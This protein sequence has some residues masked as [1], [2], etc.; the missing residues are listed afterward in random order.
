MS[1]EGLI[2]GRLRF[3]GRMAVIAIAISFFIMIVAVA[4]SSG[5]RKEIR[6][7]V[8]EVSGDVILA[9]AS[10]NYFGESDPVACDG[11]ALAEILAVEGVAD[12]TPVVYRA[13]IVKSGD[14]ISG[15]LVKGV[16]VTDTLALQV[17]IPRRLASTMRLS[18]GD[19]M[20]TYF[21]GEKVK[22]RRFKVASVYDS[23]FETGE[24]VTVYASI[25]DMRRLNGW[26]A[27][28][29]SVLEVSLEDKYRTREGMRAKARE[30]GE[31]YV[32]QAS[33]DKYGQLFDWLDLIDFNVVAILLLM[34]IV[35]GFNMISGLLILLF[36]NIS[37]IGLLKSVGMTDK[38]ISR[39]FL[40]VS[41]RLVALGMAAGNAAALLF[42]LVQGLTH[43]IRLNPENYFVS[44]VPVSVNLPFILVADAVAFILIMLL[45]LIP[46]KFIA[47]VDPAQTVKSE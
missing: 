6:D 36:Q 39:V 23:P 15:V 12:V 4:V 27:D 16:P 41:A 30:M 33:S 13:G 3:R 24:Q 35:A 21:I 17:S 44:F 45:L 11:E 2:A 43:I 40:K 37:T 20:L 28:E 9:G 38:S 22:A 1:A 14:D 19:D 7:G 46:V 18:E 5:F 8:S 31:K 34:T 42:C 25:D 26:S 32:A 47:K 29:A 10:F